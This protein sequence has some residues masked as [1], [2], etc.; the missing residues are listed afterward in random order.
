MTKDEGRLI[1]ERMIRAW[2]EAMRLRTLPVSVAGVLAGFA[3]ALA[4]GQVRVAPFVIC[5][6]FAVVAQVVSNF[7]N[8]YYDFKNG[9]DKKGREGFRRGVTEGDISPKAMKYATYAL[10]IADCL[11]GCSLII[12]GGWWMIAVGIAV[13]FFAIAYSTGP[14]PLSHRGLGDVAVVLFFGVVPVVFT[15]YLCGGTW[16]NLRLTLPIG[17]AIGLL[18]SN[19]LIVNNYRDAD[20]D[21]KVG[22]YTTVVL[23]G[24]KIM[25]VIYALN[26]TLAITT[27]ALFSLTFSSVLWIIGWAVTEIL[28]IFVWRKMGRS[29]GK[30]LN[31]VLKQTA[32]LMLLACVLLL[33]AAAV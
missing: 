15:A 18:A 10:L 22:K 9:L 6:V 16:D 30:K 19:V 24:R 5:L 29:E 14:F 12:W 3:C 27:L 31:S 13:A 7:A 2:I 26:F 20:D 17:F 21:R 11:L 25:W 33:T 4:T 8:E 32:L 28:Y 1:K 23:L